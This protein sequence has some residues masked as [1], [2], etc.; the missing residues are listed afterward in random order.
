MKFLKSFQ[1]KTAL[2]SISLNSVLGI[3]FMSIILVSCNSLKTA[4]FDQYAYQQ[5]ISLKVEGLNVMNE[6]V[7][8]Y[9][10]HEAEVETLQLDLQKMVEYEKNKPN[11]EV[12]YA[13]WKTI[14][15][16]DR[17]LL[18]G[19]LKRWKEKHQLSQVFIDEAK[20][21]VAEALDLIIKYEGQK[22]KTNEANIL[23]FLS[24]N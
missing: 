8:D 3:A 20:I 18:A 13:M 6:A 22:N 5:A 24:N 11:N 15:N 19:F 17:N 10:T 1:N 21:Q 14:A 9:M 2:T 16:E 4:V 23:N 12:S 7:N